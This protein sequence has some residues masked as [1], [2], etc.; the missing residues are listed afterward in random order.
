[1]HRI[2]ASRAGY[3]PAPQQPASHDEPN[4]IDLKGRSLAELQQEFIRATGS[5][6]AQLRLFSGSENDLRFVVPSSPSRVPSLWTRF[7]AAISHLPLLTHSMSLRAARYEVDSRGLTKPTRI[8]LRD[9]IVQ[10]VK[11]TEDS[12]FGSQRAAGERR[13]SDDVLSTLDAGGD[14]TKQRVQAV[15]DQAQSAIARRGAAPIL[16]RG[17]QNMLAAKALRRDAEREMRETEQGPLRR[18]HKGWS[19]VDPAPSQSGD[20]ATGREE[21]SPALDRAPAAVA[22]QPVHRLELPATEIPAAASM[23]PKGASDRH[24]GL[25]EHCVQT[26]KDAF[27]EPSPSQTQIDTRAQDLYARVQAFLTERDKWPIAD[28]DA[29]EEVKVV[30]A[31]MVDT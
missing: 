23:L 21:P 26:V 10:A 20:S 31:L 7:K 24:Q 15:M 25:L 8:L 27:D 30:A 1:M 14:L 28:D 2:N 5:D 4:V 16:E 9:A 17:R 6:E 19:K 13:P 29:L 11:D 12:T 18:T 3:T 22:H